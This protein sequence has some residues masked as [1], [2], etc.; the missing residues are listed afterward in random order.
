M[1]DLSP[2]NIIN[3]SLIA[4][5]LESVRK[6]KEGYEA[7]LKDSYSDEL[8][9]KIKDIDRIINEA[10]KVMGM[11]AS[12]GAKYYRE[13]HQENVDSKGE[14]NEKGIR[15]LNFLNKKWFKFMKE[16]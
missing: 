9:D 10:E 3:N 12:E 16:F 11:T 14:I 8:S 13:K 2:E 6:I 1:R 5:S 7:E 4:Q 15:R